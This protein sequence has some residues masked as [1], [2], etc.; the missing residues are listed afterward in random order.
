LFEP[1]VPN[2]LAAGAP[3]ELGVF[4]P[5]LKDMLEIASGAIRWVGDA[6]R[7]EAIRDALL[8]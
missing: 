5:K 7:Y 4:D 1:A 2:K 8:R 6:M 3:S